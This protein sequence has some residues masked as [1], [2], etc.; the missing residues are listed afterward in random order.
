METCIHRNPMNLERSMYNHALIKLIVIE[1]LRKQNETWGVFL[2]KNG[3]Q[4]T[5]ITKNHEV[6]EPVTRNHEYEEPIAE[7]HQ[8][9]HKDENSHIDEGSQRGKVF[10]QN[11][12]SNS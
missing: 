1:E 2:V 5:H 3:F 4:E 7:N 8:D 10:Q 11:E 9:S 12:G 6:K